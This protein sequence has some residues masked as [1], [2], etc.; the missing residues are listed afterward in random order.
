MFG[1]V[2]LLIIALFL[3][4][5]GLPSLMLYIPLLILFLSA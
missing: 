1:L 2:E 3:L 5:G 4:W